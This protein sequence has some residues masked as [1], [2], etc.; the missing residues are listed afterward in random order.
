MTAGRLEGACRPVITGALTSL[1]CATLEPD[2][3]V[4]PLLPHD[5]DFV[6]EGTGADMVVIETAAMLA[7]ASWAYA[8]DPAATDRGRR[9]A[10]MV[11]LARSLGKPVVLLR[12]A[13]WQLTPSWTAT[14]GSSW[15]GSTPSG[16]T[17][18]VPATRSMRPGV[19]R[20][21]PRPCGG[22]SMS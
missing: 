18:A 6:L 21:S 20:V 12:N 7:G 5:A 9:L 1:S 15:P 11:S 10:A 8:G 4:H 17:R 2:A 3:V 16:W 14:S 22:S 19:T 13:P